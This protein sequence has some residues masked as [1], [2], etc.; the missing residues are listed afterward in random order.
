MGSGCIVLVTVLLRRVIQ[1]SDADIDLVLILLEQR[2][3]LVVP[4][5]LNV[6]DCAVVTVRALLGVVGQVWL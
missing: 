6:S 3:L 5:L 4:L 1:R 2:L